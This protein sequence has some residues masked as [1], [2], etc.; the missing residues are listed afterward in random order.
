M[1]IGNRTDRKN[2]DVCVTQKKWLIMR[3]ALLILVF[4]SIPSCLAA[5]KN[6]NAP[7]IRITDLLTARERARAGLSKLTPDELKALNAALF[8]VYTELMSV[9]SADVG[10]ESFPT[11]SDINLF[12]S[13]GNAVA[14]IAVDEDSTIYLWSGQPVAYLDEDNVY[15][16]DGKH[17]GWYEKAAIYDH[18]GDVVAAIAEDFRR[19]VAIAPLKGIKQLSPLKAL[20]EMEPLKPLFHSQWSNVPAKAFFLSGAD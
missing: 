12:D 14:Y 7:G 5:Q 19:P 13:S 10:K 20:E 11:K 8:R 1:I 18:Q 16:F 9:S 15:G 17:I 3:W 2:R 6:I 4:L